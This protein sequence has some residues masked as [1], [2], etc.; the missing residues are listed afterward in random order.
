MQPVELPSSVNIKFADENKNVIVSGPLGEFSYDLSSE[1]FLVTKDRLVYVLP[2]QCKKD[3]SFFIESSHSEIIQH[4]KTICR[5]QSKSINNCL[6]G[7]C[8]RYFRSIIDGVSKGFTFVL[9]MIGVGYKAVVHDRYLD[10]TIGY[11][12]LV[13]VLIPD[14][15]SIKCLKANLIELRGINKQLLGSFASLLCSLRKQEPYNGQGIRPQNGY[16]ISKCGKKK[17]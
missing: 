14:G 5:N 2:L 8:N 3:D 11:S 7:T 4:V 17:K 1:F 9:E 15:I 12:H 6:W 16:V 10:L 13:R